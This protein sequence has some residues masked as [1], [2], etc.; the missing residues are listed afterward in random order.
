MPVARPMSTIPPW[1][2]AAAP[3][4]ARAVNPIVPAPALA[5]PGT[6]A[7][8]RPGQGPR[9][10]QQWITAAELTSWALAAPPPFTDRKIIHRDSRWRAVFAVA[11][12][13]AAR[14]NFGRA[15]NRNALCR[16]LP[17]AQIF[18]RGGGAAE[19]FQY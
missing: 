5:C 14:R 4:V 1:R 10:N 19:L 9:R 13:A 3:M 8:Q 17:A 6:C 18:A 16:V 2:F 12:S 7:P 15:V 11:L